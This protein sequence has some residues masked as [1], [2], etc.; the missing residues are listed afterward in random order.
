MPIG[1]VLADLALGLGLLALAR[2]TRQR[3]LLVAGCIVLAGPA[4]G[5]ARD[6][7]RAVVIAGPVTGS[8][9][10]LAS[11]V[12]FIC[13]ATVLGLPRPLARVLGIGLR[14]RVLAFSNRVLAL[15]ASF[16]EDSRTAQI[17]P[18][19]R[20]SSLASAAEHVATMWA[21]QPPDPAWG[22]LRDDLADACQA[23]IELIRDEAPLE[24]FEASAQAVEIGPC[25]VACDDR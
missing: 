15:E 23:R 18:D 12:A 10:L 21:L 8:L 9:A 3:S 19:R 6:G 22:V 2:D 13:W 5:V 17:E 4:I 20:D 7:L 11:V 16:V 25:T 14:S 1:L 24:D